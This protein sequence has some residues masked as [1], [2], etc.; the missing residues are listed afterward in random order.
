MPASGVEWA[1]TSVAPS[2]VAGLAPRGREWRNCPAVFDGPSPPAPGRH[3]FP[4]TNREAPTAPGRHCF[5]APNRETPPALGRGRPA[6]GSAA[7]GQRDVEDGFGAAGASPVADLD[8]SAQ[9]GGDQRA[10]DL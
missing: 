5:P 9:L 2:S 3:C 10:D 7:A 1:K 4:A 8:A 6:G